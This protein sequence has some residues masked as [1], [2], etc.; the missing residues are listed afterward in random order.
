[1]NLSRRK[2]CTSFDVLDLPLMIVEFLQR[3]VAAPL[4][5][6][7]L[8]LDLLDLDVEDLDLMKPLLE[9]ARPAR[10]R[11]VEAA[12]LRGHVGDRMRVCERWS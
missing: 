1:M 7:D 6:Q 10:L 12:G 3:D 2:S 8:A 9:P 11:Q 4:G 5:A